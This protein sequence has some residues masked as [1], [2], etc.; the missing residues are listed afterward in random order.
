[1]SQLDP[2]DMVLFCPHCGMQHVDAANAADWSNPPHRSHLCARCNFIWRPA[3]VPT[4]G[5]E[6]IQTAGRDDFSLI[7]GE[8]KLSAGAL[9]RVLW[10]QI[11]EHSKLALPSDIVVAVKRLSMRDNRRGIAGLAEALYRFAKRED[12]GAETLIGCCGFCD[13]R[14]PD[15]DNIAHDDDCPL[16]LIKHC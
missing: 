9:E 13:E 11:D 7:L 1:M 10:E 2:I 16:A 12:H 3:D 6:K 15:F 4:N 5:V 8:V 14:A